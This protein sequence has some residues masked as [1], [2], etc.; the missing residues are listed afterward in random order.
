MLIAMGLF[1]IYAGSIYNDCFSI[2]LNLFGSRFLFGGHGASDGSAQGGAF[3]EGR[4]TQASH[5]PYGVDPAWYHTANELAFFNSLKM[6][7]AVTLGVAQMVFGIVYGN[8]STAHEGARGSV[9]HSISDLPLLLSALLCRVP[10][11]A[12]CAQ[13][14]L[15]P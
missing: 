3:V 12:L 2:P 5:Y 10:L 8:T 4:P 11:Q 1:A 9:R 6:K 14:P 15:L 7:L 13:P